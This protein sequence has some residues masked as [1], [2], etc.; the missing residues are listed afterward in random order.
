MPS[1]IALG[2]NLSSNF[3]PLPA[4]KVTDPNHAA[5]SGSLISLVTGGRLNPR[6]HR[7]Q[8]RA[9]KRVARAMR[10]GQEV[11]PEMMKG[12]RREG[13]IKKMLKKDVLYMMIVNLPSEDELAMAR[14]SIAKGSK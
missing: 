1:W 5:N 7:E 14:A 10:R 2:R 9:G 4:N 12:K 8:R 6:A 13:R 11:T 3:R